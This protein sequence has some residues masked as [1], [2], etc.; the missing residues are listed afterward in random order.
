METLKGDQAFL[1]LRSGRAGRVRALSVRWLPLPPGK[2]V[3]VGL[4]TSK[5]VGKAV[6]RNLIR[7]RLREILRRM[8]L[9]SCELLVVAHPEAADASF[10]ELWRDL[11]HALKKSGLIQ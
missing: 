3:W 7:R 9:P 4:V 8:H 11:S 6:T 2:G 5:K 1:R 10:A